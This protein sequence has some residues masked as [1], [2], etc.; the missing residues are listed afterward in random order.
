[1]PRGCSTNWR[2][3]ATASGSSVVTAD[4]VRGVLGL[5]RNE[6]LIELVDALARRDAGAGLR[7]IA[8]AAESGEDV[9]Q[10]NRQFVGYLR[11]LLHLRAGGRDEEADDSARRQAAAF[12][13][14]DLVRFTHA[15][16][17]IEGTINRGSF[18]QLPM[19]IAFVEVV[20]P[21][22][23]TQPTVAA[24]EMAP[25]PGGQAYP[26]ADPMRAVPAAG[27]AARPSRRE[28]EDYA[29]PPDPTPMRPVE[30]RERVPQSTTGPM[31]Q[32]AADLEVVPRGSVDAGSPSLEKLVASW[33]QIR[34]DVKTSNTR[35]AALLASTDPSAIR[36]DQ[37]VLVSPYEFHRNKLNEDGARR[38]VEDV[39]ARYMGST[40]HLICV[41]PDDARSQARS[42]GGSIVEHPAKNGNGERRAERP[43]AVPDPLDDPRVRAAKSIFNAT[44]LEPEG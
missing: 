15:F 27:R 30:P 24:V 6:R 23:Q 12:S 16:S 34:R 11:M 43:A 38:V 37:I 22:Q 25:Q 26:S 1:M 14:Q 7:L 28:P 20:L 18:A 32:P 21:Q 40:F 33:T 19:E 42:S 44:A 3:I 9:H 8:E 17:A 13:L 5:S 36:D 2:C 39:I 10:L 35:I 41:D 31:P 29:R 4:A